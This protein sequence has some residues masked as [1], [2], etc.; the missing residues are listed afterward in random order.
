M[1]YLSLDAANFPVVVGKGSWRYYGH[2]LYSNPWHG[3]R[4]LFSPCPNPVVDA[5]ILTVSLG[6]NTLAGAL[7][8]TS[9]NPGNRRRVQHRI[10]D[11]KVPL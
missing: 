8:L 5:D 4:A 7:E 2:L 11:I 6:H 3:S 1:T 10:L 9:K